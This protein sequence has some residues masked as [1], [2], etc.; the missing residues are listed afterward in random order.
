M[1]RELTEVERRSIAYALRNPRGR[2]TA[3]RAAQ[4]SGVPKSTVYDWRRERVFNPD[5]TAA[6]PVM[7][8]YRD[9]VLL[10][11]LAWLRQGGMDRPT[12]GEK[13]ASVK[14]QLSSAVEI[15]FI[16]ATRRDVVLSGENVVDV[17]D[18]RENLLPFT[19]FY[20]LM[21]TF[22]LHEPIA[23]LRSERRGPIWAPDLVTPSDYSFISPWV[24]A[25]DP[26]IERTRIPTSAIHAL[27]F[28]RALPVEAI[29][30]LY[31]GL[32]VE[33]AEDAIALERR[34]RGIDTHELAAV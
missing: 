20:R 9:L 32:N 10:R 23:E 28:E 17:R 2:Y 26:C 29:V 5:F 27:R 15:R 22:D 12:A 16:H 33:A 31:P 14:S 3:V 11:L 19:D 6:S 18:D 34:L 30:E 25:G 1:R 21:G 4:L 8:S 7:W 13:V 24:L